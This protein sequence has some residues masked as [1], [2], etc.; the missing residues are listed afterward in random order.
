MATEK[1][2]KPSS[3]LAISDESSPE[4]GL[5]DAEVDPEPDSINP[6]DFVF[7]LPDFI[8]FLPILGMNRLREIFVFEMKQETSDI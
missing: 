1:L 5:S 4:V 8:D 7:I 2:S 6:S 3:N